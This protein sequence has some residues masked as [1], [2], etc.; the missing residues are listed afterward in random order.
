VKVALVHDYLFQ[1]G[2]AERVIAALHR[3][4]PAAP[5]YTTIADPAIV[6]A[7]LPGVDVRT[8]WMQKL[9]GLR[10]H[11]RKYF[12]F[13]PS[14]IERLDLS[15]YDVV[16][17]NSSAYAKGVKVRPDACH[18]CYCHTP[19][20]FGWNFEAYAAQEQ[21]SAL[22]RLALRP[23]VEHVRR[24]DARTAGRPTA[25]ISSS[26]AIADRIEDCYG[27]PSTIVH[28]P[29][30]VDRFAPTDESGDFHLVVSRL[31]AYKR[32]DLAVAAFNLLQRPLVIIGDGPA[33]RQ[34]ERMAGPTIRFLGRRSDDEVASHYARC[35]ALIFPGEED[36]GLT[37]LE[38]N[39][40]GRPVIA[41][42]AGGALDTV[43]EGISGV[44]FRNQTA[45][46]LGS[47][48]AA[49]DAISWDPVELR[50]H[51]DTFSEANFRIRMGRAINAIV[52]RKIGRSVPDLDDQWTVGH[53]HSE[54]GRALRA[55]G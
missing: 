28:P 40:S 13:Y 29:V 24:W 16:I 47:A 27:L 2:G 46:A 5:L 21:W 31:T 20:R 41:Y 1:S 15:E 6:G 4:F 3:L 37:P 48:V 33:R 10:Q 51:A 18:V 36:F 52:R 14:A 30:E 8:S 17:S 19:M 55:L 54:R 12:L 34:L 22:T 45:E 7:L 42:A 43:R 26:S 53:R 50:R 44:F 35:R 49:C 38:A 9:P 23:M 11:H 25:Y 32:I 39:A